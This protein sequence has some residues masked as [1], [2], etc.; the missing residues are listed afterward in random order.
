MVAIALFDDLEYTGKTVTAK[1]VGY[2]SNS[3][4][5]GYVREAMTGK[6]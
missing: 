6:R 3:V 1:V 2:S 5:G 4:K